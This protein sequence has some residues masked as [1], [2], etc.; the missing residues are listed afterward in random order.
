MEAQ[1][2][3]R[4]ICHPDEDMFCGSRLRDWEQGTSSKMKKRASFMKFVVGYE[5]QA[6]MTGAILETY[7]CMG[8]G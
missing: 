3:L 2:P 6:S 5:V 1:I 4:S 7:C 8:E